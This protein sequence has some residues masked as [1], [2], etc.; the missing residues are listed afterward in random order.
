MAPLAEYGWRCGVSLGWCDL[1]DAGREQ[2]GDSAS[3]VVP[4]GVKG[5]WQCCVTAPA[6]PTHFQGW[7][8]PPVPRPSGSSA[9]PGFSSSMMGSECSLRISLPNTRQGISASPCR[10]QEAP[11]HSHSSMQRSDSPGGYVGQMGDETGSCLLAPHVPTLCRS[12]RDVM[13]LA[14]VGLNS[15]AATSSPNTIA[16]IWGVL[17]P[18]TAPS[19]ATA[20][21]PLVVTA[22]VDNQLAPPHMSGKEV[23][24]SS[25]EELT[26]T[27][28]RSHIQASMC[29]LISSVGDLG[30]CCR[31]DCS[32]W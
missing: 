13:S 11:V 9:S 2:A 19:H 5:A 25:N 1:Q 21:H 32:R 26:L 17:S 22:L 23:L 14:L 24:H 4:L 27:V 20:L 29:L 18:P 10:P 12:D 15:R 3:Y 6:W 31:H 7:G 28:N 30:G 16:S 8:D